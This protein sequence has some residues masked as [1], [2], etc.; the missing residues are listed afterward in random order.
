MTSASWWR[1]FPGAVTVCD[2]EGIILEMNDK[3]RRGYA[4]D[5]GPALIG[6]NVLDCHPEPARGKLRALLAEGRINVY[7]IEKRGARKLIYQAPWY[8]AGAY[9]GFVEV[10]LEIPPE[11]PHFVRG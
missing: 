2:R 5:G 3:A 1:E 8:E 10:S 7:T 9:A 11:M 4:A 6:T